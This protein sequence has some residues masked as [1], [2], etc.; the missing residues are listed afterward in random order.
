MNDIKDKGFTL[1]ELMIVVVV[2]GIIAAVAIPAYSDYVNRA[3]RADA[4]HG[5]LAIQLAQEKWRVN[6]PSYS[7]NM[8]DLSFA[9]DNNQSS[10]DG[11]YI[12]DIDNGA[13]TASYTARATINA[14]TGQSGDACGN[15]I[16]TVTAASGPIYSTSSGDSQSCWQR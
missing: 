8:T 10:V 7:S 11:F 4:K 3:R 1:I 9:G 16:L 12:L 13:S 15:F 6:N 14:S 5:L 2:V